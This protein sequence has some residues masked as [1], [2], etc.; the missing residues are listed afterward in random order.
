MNQSHVD[1][2][3]AH[4]DESAVLFVL[5]PGV[6]WA[7]GAYRRLLELL[8]CGKVQ[9]LIFFHP[10]LDTFHNPTHVYFSDDFILAGTPP[11]NPSEVTVTTW[12]PFAQALEMV[13]RREILDSLT[14][15]ALLAYQ[16]RRMH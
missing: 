14:I 10:G 7:D 6:V 9:P 16:S 8:R 4:E 15:T 1:F 5:F 12:V 2:I 11:S 13:F 3:R